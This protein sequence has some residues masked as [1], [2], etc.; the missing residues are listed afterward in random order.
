MKRREVI[1]YSTSALLASCIPNFSIGSNLKRLD[2]SDVRRRVSDHFESLLQGKTYGDY[3][4]GINT[5]IDLYASCD[6]A[7]ARQIMGENMINNLS[8]GRR[9]EWT[10]Y[11]NSFQQ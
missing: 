5:R 1:K 10:D 4:T 11:I 8:V 6:V 2:L 3:G 7:I 9:R